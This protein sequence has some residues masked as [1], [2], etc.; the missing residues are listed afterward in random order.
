MLKAF[1]HYLALILYEDGYKLVQA[2]YLG[3]NTKVP[4]PMEMVLRM[5]TLVVI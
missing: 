5:D 4:L 2:P 3:W 1:E